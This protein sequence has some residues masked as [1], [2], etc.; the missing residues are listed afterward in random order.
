MNQNE[1]RAMADRK[2][3]YVKLSGL[4]GNAFSIMG[5]ARSAMREC[6]WTNAEI[7]EATDDMMAGDYNALL[8]AVCKYCEAD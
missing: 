1:I 5:R 3:P 4:D 7:G 2:K 6:G 8:R